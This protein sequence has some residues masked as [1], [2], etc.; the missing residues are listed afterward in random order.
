MRCKYISSFV[1]YL[2]GWVKQL[3]TQLL[4]VENYGTVNVTDQILD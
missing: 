2:D 3:E 4:R 1:Q